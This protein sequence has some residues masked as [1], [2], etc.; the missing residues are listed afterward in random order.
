[1]PPHLHE[2][3]LNPDVLCQCVVSHRNATVHPHVCLHNSYWRSAF[4]A[5]VS[6]PPASPVI[7]ATTDTGSIKP[8]ATGLFAESDSFT[9]G[10][11]GGGAQVDLTQQ[12]GEEEEQEEGRAQ[13]EAACQKWGVLMEAW[14]AA[15]QQRSAA[16]SGLFHRGSQEAASLTTFLVSEKGE[17]CVSTCMVWSECQRK[18]CAACHDHSACLRIN[19]V[20]Y[21]SSYM[22]CLLLTCALA[23]W[24]GSH[25]ACGR[26]EPRLEPPLH[27]GTVLVPMP[28]LM[29]LV[30]LCRVPGLALMQSS[31]VN[32]SALPSQACLQD[33]TAEVE[34]SE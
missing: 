1:V 25:E 4:S 27:A 11:L 22:T 30:Y 32:M 28:L 2:C 24:D 18:R 5:S 6:T 29:L 26:A 12:Q 13:V 10:Q 23:V 20:L 21:L 8:V 9:G 15:D 19:E 33:V 17:G 34:L 16:G 31:L 7:K 14:L 3:Q